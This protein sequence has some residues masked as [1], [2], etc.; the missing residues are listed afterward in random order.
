MKL[1]TGLIL[2]SSF[3][4]G[5]GVAS[6]IG[7]SDPSRYQSLIGASA[8]A[9]DA[10]QKSDSPEETLKLLNLFGSVL[11]LVKNDY[12]EPV[13]DKKLIENALDGLVGNLDPH[14]SFMTEK[15]YK[16]MMTQISGKFGG[17]GRRSFTKMDMS[18]L[19]RRLRALR[20]SA[21]G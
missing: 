4:A 1:R 7:L 15:Q 20:P 2:G 9:R 14:S 16:E 11:D 12:V 17:W 21:P 18:A 10:S 13:T 8:L 5:L 6:F 19:Y 3:L